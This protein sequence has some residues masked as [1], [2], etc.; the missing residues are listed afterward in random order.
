VQAIQRQHPNAK[1]TWVIGKIEK[2]LLEGLAGVE[3]VVFDKSQGRAAFR[4]LKQS[5]QGQKFDVLLHMQVALRANWAAH[6]ISAK[7]KIG[8]DGGRSKEMHSLFINERIKSQPQAHVLEGFFAFAEKLGVPEY[9]KQALAWDIPIPEQDQAFAQQHIPSLN[10]AASRTFIIS[11]AASKAERNWLPERCAALA[12]YAHQQGFTIVLCGGPAAIDKQLGDSIE[13]HTQAPIV[14][15]IGQTSLKQ[16]LALL[17]NASLVLAPDTGPA[18][19]AVSQKTPVIGLYGHSNPNRTGPYLYQQYTA[20]VY[21]QNLL[22]Q[23]GKN[24]NELPWGMRVKGEDIMAQITVEQVIHC[25]KK[26][27]NDFNL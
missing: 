20:E 24:V 19:M 16:M 8:F 22:D 14:N 12:D 10:N 6:C 7:R 11:P 15:L 4:Q 27:V 21:H 5:L 13:Q 9:P 3:F 23:K 1:I 26:I 18:H 17:G 2:V 25:F